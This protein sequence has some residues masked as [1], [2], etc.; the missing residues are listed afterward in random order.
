M[1]PVFRGIKHRMEAA[2][3]RRLQPGFVE[4]FVRASLDDVGGR[5]VSREFGAI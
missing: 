3:A 4:A 2:L 5:I 1:H